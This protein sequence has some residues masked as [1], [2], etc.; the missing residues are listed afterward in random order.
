M[1]H[2]EEAGIHSGDSSCVLPSVDL[3]RGCAARQIRAHTRKLA[4]ALNVIGLVNIQFA[5]QRG[6][7]FV[8][9][10][11]PPGVAHGSVCVEGGGCAAGEDC[12]A[13]DGGAEG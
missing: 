10:V 7:V 8:I 4:K 13:A 6:K 3:K 12:F 1:Q 9:E 5:I 11:N 2:I